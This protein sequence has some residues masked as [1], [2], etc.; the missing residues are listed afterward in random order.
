MTELLFR[1][2]I[3]ALLAV[4]A[5]LM[6][7][8][9]FRRIRRG[10]QEKPGV[11]WYFKTAVFALFALAWLLVLLVALYVFA[12]WA[13]TSSRNYDGYC[14]WRYKHGGGLPIGKVPVE[15]DGIIQ[16]C[17]Y[18][19]HDEKYLKSL[20]GR[21]FTTEER[22]DIAINYY[23]CDQISADY[24]EIRE[25]EGVGWTDLRE[26]FTLIPYG[27]KSEFLQENPDCC[28]LTPYT[29]PQNRYGGEEL[30]FH[31]EYPRRGNERA[32][33]M[34]DGVFDFKHKIRYMDQ[35][36]FRKE[37]ES[38]IAFILVS[39]CGVPRDRRYHH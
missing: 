5:Y 24:K 8:Y 2:G 37:I 17:T 39:N 28:E 29:S 38:T 31:D 6:L 9:L 35:E 20:Y 12:T 3:I 15:Q 7:A 16:S 13:Y 33:G 11:G 1:F 18:S 14:T 21:R 30:W 27:S 4:P 25:A 22:L 34:G 19:W 10:I 32:N 23:L 36:G 26:R